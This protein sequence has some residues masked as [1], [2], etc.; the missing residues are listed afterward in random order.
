MGYKCEKCKDTGY[1]RGSNVMM[2]AK[3]S[4]CGRDKPDLGVQVFKSTEIASKPAET[5]E[6]SPRTG[7]PKR[8][9]TRRT[10]K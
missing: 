5:P 4:P 7:K 8:K 1:I 2:P 6:I 9:W 10:S 3:C